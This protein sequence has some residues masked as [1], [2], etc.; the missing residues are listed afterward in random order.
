MKNSIRNL[1]AILL[2]ILFGAVEAQ[3]IREGPFVGDV[4]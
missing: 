4:G 3:R 1:T 2:A